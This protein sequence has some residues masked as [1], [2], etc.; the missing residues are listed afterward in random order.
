MT[1]QAG[2]AATLLIGVLIYA[3]T[4]ALIGAFVGI[5]TLLVRPKPGAGSSQG[6]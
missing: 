1:R 5:Y 4:V 2:V 3:V 6:G